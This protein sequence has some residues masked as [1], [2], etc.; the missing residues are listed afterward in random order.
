MEQ[1]DTYVEDHSDLAGRAAESK[2]STQTVTSK[3]YKCSNTVTIW[4]PK[5]SDL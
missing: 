2:A 4:Q 3:Y 5:D 1:L